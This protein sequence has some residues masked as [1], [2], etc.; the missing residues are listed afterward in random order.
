MRVYQDT[1]VQDLDT[2]LCKLESLGTALAQLIAMVS[3]TLI[4]YHYGGETGFLLGVGVSQWIKYIADAWMAE[5]C[6][7]WHWKFDLP[8]LVVFSGLAYLALRVS[9]WLAWRFVL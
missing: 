6:G 1:D 5:R 2:I 7:I 9:E 8:V 4:G 3:A